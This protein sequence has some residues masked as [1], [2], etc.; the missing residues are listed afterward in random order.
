MRKERWIGSEEQKVFTHYLYAGKFEG[1]TSYVVRDGVTAVSVHKDEKGALTSM[2][3][4]AERIKRN[5]EAEIARVIRSSLDS[6]YAD[7]DTLQM[8][9]MLRFALSAELAQYYIKKETSKETL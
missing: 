9:L 1:D 8:T 5:G 6:P 3:A 4:Q 7:M 2:K